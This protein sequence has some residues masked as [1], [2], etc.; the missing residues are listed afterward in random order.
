MT[1]FKFF[2]HWLTLIIRKR[3]TVVLC[4]VT[5]ILTPR[6][7]EGSLFLGRKSLLEFSD[8]STML[9]IKPAQD[10]YRF[11]PF[12][13]NSGI[14]RRFNFEQDA[15]IQESFSK[16]SGG[17]VEIDED[18]N[19]PVSIFSQEVIDNSSDANAKKKIKTHQDQD[20]EI[21]IAHIIFIQLSV[22]L[23]GCLISFLFR[24]PYWD[25]YRTIKRMM[26]AADPRP[27]RAIK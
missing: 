5:T 3:L 7:S 26:Q 22:F 11:L 12:V 14:N 27:K 4:I 1:L 19:L 8:S 24:E 20:E 10:F 18:P 21:P 17:G 25:R 6:L 13:S 15:D 23:L 2:V 9:W 16:F